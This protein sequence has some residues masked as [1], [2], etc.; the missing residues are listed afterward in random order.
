MSLKV[1]AKLYCI[2]AEQ[3]SAAVHHSSTEAKLKY[4]AGKGL[5]SFPAALFGSF[6]GKQK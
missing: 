3:S 5:S 1:Q 2:F 6:L 4:P